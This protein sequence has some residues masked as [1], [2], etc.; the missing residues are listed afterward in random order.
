MADVDLPPRPVRRTTLRGVVLALFA[1][2]A[3]GSVA[4]QVDATARA[5]ERARMLREIEADF[6]ATA[7]AT[8]ITAPSAALMKALAAVPRERFVP[9]AQA[10]FAYDNRPLPIGDGQT[11]S[12]PFIVALMTELLAVTQGARVLEVGTGSGYQAAILAALGARVYSIE[13]IAS[14]A[15]RARAALDSAG[16]GAV[17]TRVGD[18]YRGWPEAAP[19]DAIIVTA[20]P[21]HVPPAL[22]EQLKPGGRLV[23]P[24]G[25]TTFAQDLLLIRK[26][27]NGRAVTQRTLPVRFVPLTRER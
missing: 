2:L 17:E 3:G 27:A 13:I 18:G 9:P 15:V 20:A 7:A 5:G 11:I 1:W 26:E 12:Q 10:A 4:A 6:R 25:P 24:V 19:F 16:Y 14:L 23:I 22:V 8:G 21:D